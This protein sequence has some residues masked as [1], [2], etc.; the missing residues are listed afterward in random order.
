VSP[1]D[2][3]TLGAVPPRDLGD[4]RLQAHHAAQVVSS[5]GATFLEPT[6]DD[7]HP[8]LGWSDELGGLVARCVT[9]ECAFRLVL[10]VG[11]LELALIEG[12]GERSALALEG[13]TLEQ[14]FAWL[15]A[16]VGEVTELP[17]GGIQ[18][19]AYDLPK[20]P[21]ATGAAFSR[22]PAAAFAELADWLADGNA[23]LG[24]LA[25]RMEGASDVRVWPHHFDVGL[26]AVLA[27]DAQGNATRTIGAGLSPGDESYPEPYWYVSPWPYP[28]RAENLPALSAGGHWHTQGFTS[29][30]LTASELLAGGS[31]A[32]SARAAA[33]LDDAVAASR[34]V[35]TT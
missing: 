23:S 25:A 22:E 29:A 27:G 24:A 18:R 2:W 31:A 26:L 7:S 3:R 20:H 11:A 1:A 17:P 4:A 9:S 12:G 5:V 30:I 13:K 35:L 10:R 28:E 32:Q 15:G 33:F 34:R 6:S 8:N 21:V 19:T 16:A 14:A